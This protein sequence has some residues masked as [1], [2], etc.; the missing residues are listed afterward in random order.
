MA[1]DDKAL[2]K[3]LIE[4]LK[5]GQAHVTPEEV[6]KDLKPELCSVRPQEGVHSVYEEIEHMRIA[7]EDIL[8]YTLDPAWESPEWPD[9]YW[10]S[11]NDKLTQVILKKAVSGFFRDLKELIALVKNPK[12]DLTAQIPHGEGH[13]YLREVLLVADHNAYHLGKIVQKLK[14][15]GE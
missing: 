7:Q 12:F 8:R 14:Q 4:L 6:L 13:T 1:M 9:G 2:R 15:L 10:P 11:D 3:N 5:G